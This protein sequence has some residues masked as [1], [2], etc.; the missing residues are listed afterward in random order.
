[1]IFETHKL[2]HTISIQVKNQTMR[3]PP[4]FAFGAAVAPI[5]IGMAIIKA[6]GRTYRKYLVMTEKCRILS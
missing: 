1:M 5:I 4:I 6:N 2:N 3:T